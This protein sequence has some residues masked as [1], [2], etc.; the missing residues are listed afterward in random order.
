MRSR[1]P[2]VPAG[3]RDD[4][5]VR[6]GGRMHRGQP[7]QYRRRHQQQHALRSI[8]RLSG[9]LRLHGVRVRVAQL[10]HRAQ[11]QEFV[12][13][14]RCRL[15][16]RERSSFSLRG[17]H[18]RVQPHRRGRPFLRVLHVGLHRSLVRAPVLCRTKLQRRRH[19]ARQ[20]ELLRVANPSRR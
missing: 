2:S 20:I 4:R 3:L 16:S 18:R 14:P 19:G 9:S 7:R 13:P 17:H 8:V 5:E 1:V 12:V 11:A 6:G 15:S 10:G